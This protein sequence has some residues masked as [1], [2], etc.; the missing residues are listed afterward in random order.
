M[1]NTDYLLQ[2]TAYGFMEHSP[3]E[4]L[5]PIGSCYRRAYDHFTIVSVCLSHNW[6][7][8]MNVLDVDDLKNT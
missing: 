2:I 5:S 1:C 6:L 4:Q 7:I 3:N 8:R